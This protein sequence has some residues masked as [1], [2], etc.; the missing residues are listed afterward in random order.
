MNEMSEAGWLAG[1][2]AGMRAEPSLLT[3]AGF[4]SNWAVSFNEPLGQ[5]LWPFVAA[6]CSDPVDQE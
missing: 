4:G 6:H 2:L 1:W 3:L 5:P